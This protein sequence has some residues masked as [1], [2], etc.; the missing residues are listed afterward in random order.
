MLPIKLTALESQR[1]IDV[2]VHVNG[3]GRGAKSR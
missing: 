1:L 2:F 3:M